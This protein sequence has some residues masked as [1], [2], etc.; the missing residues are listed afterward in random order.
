MILCCGEALIDMLP[1]Q[2]A[3]G[4]PA[5]AP[6]CGGAVFNTA[7][8][9]GRLG[10]KVSIFTGLSTDFLGRQLDDALRAS[11]VRTDLALH[12]DRPTPLAFVRLT[13]GQAEYSFY[14]EN[15][16]VQMLTPGDA[17]QIDDEIRALYFSGI[18]LCNAPV[19]DTMQALCVRAAAHKPVMIDPNIRP[20]FVADIPA[21]RTRLAN[22]IAHADIVKMSDEDLAWLDPSDT[23][24]DQ[25]AQDILAQGCSLFVIT[26]GSEGAI[27]YTKSG[28][29]VTIQ[30][31]KVTVI[32]TVGAGDTFNAGLMAKLTELGV[33]T[34]PALAQI[35]ADQITQAL[36]FAA[37]IAAISVT[38]AGANPPWRHDLAEID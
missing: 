24:V 28:E 26:R 25:K 36:T 12:V 11:H 19:A 33:M 13:D 29:T 17:P 21:Y 35:G 15:S 9:L 20:S 37:Q 7:I 1:A 32:D 3:Q 4:Q 31:P 22:M 27:A 38:R 34:K 14:N 2:T 23:S 5:M 30:A 16:A 8:A 10:T 6:H 18:S